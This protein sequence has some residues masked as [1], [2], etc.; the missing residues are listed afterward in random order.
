MRT[1]TFTYLRIFNLVFSTNFHK[2]SFVCL[3][4]PSDFWL[5]YFNAF[6]QSE[7]PFFLFYHT[8]S[9]VMQTSLTFGRTFSRLSREKCFKMFLNSSFMRKRRG[10]HG[11]CNIKSSSS[12]PWICV[13][14][15]NLSSASKEPC[16][17]SGINAN[18]LR[19]LL[20]HLLL[21][22]QTRPKGNMMY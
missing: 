6:F 10:L 16:W 8:S 12:N 13:D 1:E 3:I 22:V 4:S 9:V 18:V 2:T 15:C 5:S 19:E 14:D 17:K 7:M 20:L 21:G 11:I